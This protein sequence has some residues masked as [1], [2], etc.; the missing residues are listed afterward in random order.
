[1]NSGHRS[2]TT[3]SSR[4]LDPGQR[5]FLII[6]AAQWVECDGG[7]GETQREKEREREV[8]GKAATTR[9]NLGFIDLEG[10]LERRCKVQQASN[11]ETG[12]LKTGSH[13]LLKQPDI[14][15]SR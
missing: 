1:M 6:S 3:H 2:T 4:T 7:G 10:E 11:E 9:V 12:S 14:Y 13:L 15:L 8:M 5:C